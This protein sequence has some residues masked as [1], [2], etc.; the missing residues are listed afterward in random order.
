MK[1][2]KFLSIL[3][4][5]AVR[6]YITL[7]LLFFGLII[8]LAVLSGNYRQNL[9]DL[10]KKEIKRKVEISLNA[11]QP[12]IDR[13]ENGE[14][15]RGES[16]DRI[17]ELAGRM[18]YSSET[19]EN[20]IFMSSYEGI[21]LVQPLEPWLEGTYQLDAYDR[22]GN[23]YIRDLIE[24]AKSPDGEG[25]VSYD[26]APPGSQN[27][28][29]KLSYV[30]GIPSLQCYI[31]TGMFYNDIDALFF[32]YLLSPLLFIVIGF[33]GISLLL[34]LY[35]RPQM[36]CLKIL[37]DSFHKISTDPSTFPVIPE[38]NFA[39]D[40]DE[41]EILD[42][43]SSMLSTL[44]DYRTE[45]RETAEMYRYLYEESVGV[46]MIIDRQGS[47][48]DIN[49]SFLEVIGH[50]KEELNNTSIYD[51]F[52][53]GQEIKLER[54]VNEV[55][56][57]AY[58]YAADFDLIDAHGKLRTIL[59][60]ESFFLPKDENLILLTGVDITNRKH[61]ERQA[62]LSEEQLIR[63]DK[64]SSLG[65]LVAGVAHEINNPNQFLMSS[66]Q[67]LEDIWK[68]LR[69]ALDEFY[70][71]NGDFVS[72]GLPYSVLRD[73]IP[74]YIK[75]I[76]DGS[77]RIHKIVTD[78]KSFAREDADT[79]WSE[80]DVNILAEAAVSLCHNMIK[81]TTNN[82]YVQF[83]RDLPHVRGNTQK[84]EQ[85]IINLIQNACQALQDKNARIEIQTEYVEKEG[86]V[87]VTVSDEGNG[88]E[89]EKLKKIF[90]PFFTTK[91]ED[92]GT[93]LGLSISNTIV[94]DHKGQ[95]LITSEKG[96][97]TRAS[98]VLPVSERK[99]R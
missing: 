76:N 26:Y 36:K 70:D 82:F 45:V 72:N 89:E 23:Y 28:G 37:V 79:A 13:Y 75:N 56:T 81:N 57:C 52:A 33:S 30:R 88:I 6:L 59:F 4:R 34:F 63:A 71:E 65:V 35:L 95:L 12:L 19:M 74:D 18:T 24:A 94:T 78:L 73:K 47:I 42:G 97:G 77:R 17:T 84:L 39:E 80:I 27:S 16:I 96:K 41:R 69:P 46:R 22:Y 61:A 62:R 98:V 31:G 15:T 2:P 21:M 10:R 48:K 40:S 86:Q 25:F 5:T 66:S 11:I 32:D 50:F 29:S 91:R 20:Y 38:S 53:P 99:K 93:G 68:G 60:S 43:F 51:F 92:G 3:N 1:R 87:V 44:K 8:V 7:V 54:L 90:D 67:L 83:E 9:I 14:L 58:T 64:L 85:V 49:N 55:T